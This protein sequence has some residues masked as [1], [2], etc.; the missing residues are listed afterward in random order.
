MKLL[1]L[2]KV[3]GKNVWDLLKLQVSEDQK[4][5]VADNDIKAVLLGKNVSQIA[6]LTKACELCEEEKDSVDWRCIPEKYWQ[7]ALN[8]YR[9]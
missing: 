8:E 7:M 5:F 9:I 1:R 2:E 6:V 3:N 4:S